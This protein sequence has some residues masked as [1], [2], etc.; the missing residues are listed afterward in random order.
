[1]A[2]RAALVLALGLLA[3]APAWAASPVE[4]TDVR[5][6]RRAGGV[7]VELRTS[8]PP[9]YRA[10]LIDGPWRVVLDLE[11]ALYRVATVPLAVDA[12]PVRAIRGSQYRKGVA[13][14]V[15]EL[16]SRV[17]WRVEAHAGGLS[18]LLGAPAG[19]GAAPAPPPA[20]P[21]PPRPPPRT[22]PPARDRRTAS[23]SP[24]ATT[25]RSPTSARPAR[26]RPGATASARRSAAGS[27]RPS[28]RATSCSAR[29]PGRSSSSWMFPSRARRS[30]LEASPENRS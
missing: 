11:D 23:V 14:V 9:R 18:V 4:L 17:P 24:S 5:V 22:P 12:D 6:A 28:A 16:T 10:E 30:R 27:S 1:M 15:I 21:A 3:A 8:A 29:P 7:S 20:A 2:P 26:R 19:G 13:R 25:V